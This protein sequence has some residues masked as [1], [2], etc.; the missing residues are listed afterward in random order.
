M[1]FF[2]SFPSLSK[3]K[4]KEPLGLRALFKLVGN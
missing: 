4:A 2:N 1:F 3:Q